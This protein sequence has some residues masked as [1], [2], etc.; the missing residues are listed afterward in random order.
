MRVEVDQ[1]GKVESTRVAT[2]LAFSNETHFSILI[3]TST[4]KQCH[5]HLKDRRYLPKTHHLRLFVAAP[6][7]LLKDH[8]SQL[9]RIVVDPEYRGG[10]ARL[11]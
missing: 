10:E 4:K 3:S 1:S 8:V 7:L 11:R 2:V 6:V 5:K 9:D